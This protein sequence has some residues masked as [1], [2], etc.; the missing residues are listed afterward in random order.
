MIIDTEYSYGAIILFIL[1]S[2]LI[3]DY[4]IKKISLIILLFT[5]VQYIT[6]YAKCGLLEL[7]D[8][9]KQ[10]PDKPNFLYQI[11][12]PLLKAPNNY[13]DKKYFW[14]HLIF[15]F[16]I[17]YQIINYKKSYLVLTKYLFGKN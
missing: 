1:G 8:F 14:I 5:F 11:L 13:F 4:E 12:L 6:T 15:I 9:V 2:I 16:V 7:D 10:N 17:A 3:P